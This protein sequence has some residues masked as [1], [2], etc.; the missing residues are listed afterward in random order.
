MNLSELSGKYSTDA[1]CHE[2]LKKL[3][4]PKGV[5]C[6][7][8][9]SKKIFRLSAQSKFECGKC[10]YQ[11]TATVGTVFQDSHIPLEKWFQAVLL[12]C[13]ARKGF[14]ANQMKR[15]LG[16]GCYRTAWYLCHRIRAAMI[17]RQKSILGGIVEMD[18]TYFGGKK[19]GITM[20]DAKAAKQI[21]LGI[22]QRGGELRFFQAKNVTARTLAEF[23]KGN[24]SK[25]V[26][27][28]V[29]D[30][31][32]SYPYAA[33]RSGVSRKHKT[34][35]HKETYVVGNIHTNTIES[36]FSL[37]KRG[38]MGTWHK[39]SAKHLPA[40]LNEM[41]FR[42]NR[43]NDLDLFIDT[44]RHMITTRTLPYKRLIAA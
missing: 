6:P 2:L 21:V 37:F 18:E 12:L 44:L 8:C 11:F 31:F 14:S 27:M 34:I 30:E 16:I 32:M 23:I 19:K 36:A 3:R 9:E 39:L 33:Q 35:K 13:E 1:K 38:V 41:T 24:V 20:A 5:I 10:Q 17:E 22:R 4:W 26:E 28:F 40:Y 42:F 7:R 25:D 29:T 15:T 43:R